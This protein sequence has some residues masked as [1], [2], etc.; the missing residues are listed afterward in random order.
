MKAVVQ[1]VS[2]ARVSVSGK[3][4]AAIGPGLLVLL[5]V[6]AQDNAQDAVLLARKLAGLR[7][8][9]DEQRLMNLSIDDINGEMLL[10]SQFTLLASTRKGNRP[11]FT[12]AAGPEKASELFD[13][14][15]SDLRLRGLRV[16]TG[17]FGEMMEVGL[18]NDGPVTII[19]DTRERV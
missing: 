9:S 2:Q 4:V 16:A 17:I 13:A 8:F 6:A 11:S 19:L 18:I 15:V 5:G 3:P 1:R 7:I 12:A 14:V 10:V